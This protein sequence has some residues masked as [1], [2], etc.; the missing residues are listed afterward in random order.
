M[1]ESLGEFKNKN[2]VFPDNV[3]IYRDG[4]GDS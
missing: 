3:V 1:S 4:V 2:G